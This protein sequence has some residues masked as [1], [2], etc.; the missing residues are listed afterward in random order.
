M[1]QQIEKIKSAVDKYRDSILETERYIW[2][3]PETGFKEW[4]TN[5]HLKEKYEKLGYTVHEA[6]NIPGFYVEI[7][8]GREGPCVLILGE[9]DSVICPEHPEC[10]KE[11]GAVHSCGHNTHSAALLGIAAALTEDGILDELCGRIKLC[12]VPAEELLEIE[13]RAELKKQGI[14]KYFGGKSEFLYRGYFD[15]VD[16]AF[17]VHA[18]GHYGVR[19]GHHVGCIVKKIIYKGKAAHAGGAPHMGRN[20]LYAATCGLNAVNA[21]RET[22]LNMDYI[23]VHPIMTAGGSMVN[24]IPSEARLESYV[25]GKTFEA[26]KK[27]N[28]KVNQAL[29]GAALSLGTNIEIVDYPG[30][31][32]TVHDSNL[33]DVVMDAAAAII[34]EHEFRVVNGVATGST[35]MGD[36]SMIMPVQHADAAGAKGTGHGMDYY[37]VDPVTA[38]V[39]SAKLQLMMVSLLLMN[40]GERAKKIIAEYKPT[41]ATKEEFLSFVDSINDSGDRIEYLEDGTAKVRID[42]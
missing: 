19:K 10:D 20:S 7:D 22:F 6:G 35:D 30:Y 21:I 11:T 17:M 32:P 12:A 18:G 27:V 38:C 24:A 5:A 40:N 4:K 26:M 34:P 31:S 33:A 37:I 14:I 28:R 1:E 8:T 15:D 36:L 3:N 16:L 25:R 41:F 42:K 29:V 23:R 9:M 39:D 2:N 13:Y